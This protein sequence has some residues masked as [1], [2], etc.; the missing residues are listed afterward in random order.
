MLKSHDLKYRVNDYV[1]SQ[2]VKLNYL[3]SNSLTASFWIQDDD[4]DGPTKLT[5]HY[6]W[7]FIQLITKTFH[8]AKALIINEGFMYI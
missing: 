5:C 8:H 2:F 3:I 1:D 6:Y 4:R 7:S